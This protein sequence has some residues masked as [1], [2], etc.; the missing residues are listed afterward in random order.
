[1]VTGRSACDWSALGKN[2]GTVRAGDVVDVTAVVRQLDRDPASRSHPCRCRPA[3]SRRP[4]SASGARQL[5]GARGWTLAQERGR[6]FLSQ[7]SAQL[8]ADTARQ[9]AQQFSRVDAETRQQVG[10]LLVVHFVGQLLR[11]LGRP[12][13][14]KKLMMVSLPI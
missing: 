5:Y 9:L 2:T 13:S 4:L 6:Y 1:M 14:F 11:C 8:V 10:L 3:R 12:W 7:A